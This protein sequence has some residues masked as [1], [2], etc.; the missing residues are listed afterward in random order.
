MNPVIANFHGIGTPPARVDDGERPYWL[1]RE[2]FVRALDLLA[3]SGLPFRVTF[4]DGNLS[5][6]ET[7]VPLCA[8]RGVE[9]IVFACSGRIGRAGYLAAADLR[10]LAAMPGCRIGSH[11]IDHVPW[12]GLDP[13]ALAAEVAQS[14]AVLEA[15]LAAPVAAAGIPFG[16]YDRRV[17][18]ALRRAGYREVYSSDGGPRLSAGGVQPR[19]SLRG[20]RPVEAQVAAL[21]AATAPRR[22]VRQELRLRL[23]EL[24]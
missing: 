23:K 17:L 16:A 14:R 5:D 9:S 24:R 20:D 12:R 10:A 6:V 8:E 11:G 7:G 21:L 18:A 4:D 19:L 15:A 1:S 22:R 2:G 13:A 3:A